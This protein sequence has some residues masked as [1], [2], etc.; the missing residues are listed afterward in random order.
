MAE[1]KIHPVQAALNKR[2]RLDFEA[3]TKLRELMEM[4][5]YNPGRKNLIKIMC[6]YNGYDADENEEFLKEVERI[7]ESRDEANEEFLKALADSQRQG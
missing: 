1:D 2:D 5:N 3:L 4:I 7:I 6:E